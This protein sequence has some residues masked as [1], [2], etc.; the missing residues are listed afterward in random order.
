MREVSHVSFSSVDA[1]SIKEGLCHSGAEE[2]ENINLLGVGIVLGCVHGL[3][4][5]V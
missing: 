3:E 1:S 2:E 4:M 5:W